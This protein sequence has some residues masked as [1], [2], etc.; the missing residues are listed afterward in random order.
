MTIPTAIQRH[1]RALGMKSVRITNKG[2]NGADC[3]V[4]FQRNAVTEYVQITSYNSRL[5]LSWAVLG[6]SRANP[7]LQFCKEVEFDLDEGVCTFLVRS[8]RADRF[9]Q[10]PLTIARG[11]YHC[12]ASSAWAYKH[13]G[14]IE[15][16]EYWHIVL[17]DFNHISEDSILEALTVFWRNRAITERGNG[18]DEEMEATEGATKTVLRTHRKREAK[19]RV[20]KLRQAMANGAHLICEVP[21]CGFDFEARYGNLG[22]GY[23]EVH[24]MVPLASR[25][26]KGRKTRLSDL[27]IVC[28][29]CHRMIHKGGVSRPLKGLIKE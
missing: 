15:K 29:N 26:A 1:L 9:L 22:F 5:R 27:V 21:G 2:R 12:V 4:C 13:R 18:V 14:K 8:A 28:A 11:N 19:L 7:L 3:V 16:D 6:F 23:A 10:R 25:T 24:H 17:N 20:E